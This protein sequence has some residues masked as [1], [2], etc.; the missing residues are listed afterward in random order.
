MEQR[1]NYN[2]AALLL[3]SAPAA[4]YSMFAILWFSRHSSFGELI[5]SRDMFWATVLA[6]PLCAIVMVY[7]AHYTLRQSIPPPLRVTVLILNGVAFL[8]ALSCFGFLLLWRG[9]N[10][11]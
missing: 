6:S 4:Y 1:R 11:Q 9:I 7:A 5:L 3:L 8:S 10:L 2:L